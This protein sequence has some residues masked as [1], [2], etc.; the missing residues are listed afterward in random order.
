MSR[1]KTLMNALEGIELGRSKPTCLEKDG[2]EIRRMIGYILELPLLLVIAREMVEP[3]STMSS[4]RVTF[5]TKEIKDLL[6]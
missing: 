3:I 4:G 6:C 1:V 5:K 2:F